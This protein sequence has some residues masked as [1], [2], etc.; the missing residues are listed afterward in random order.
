MCVQDGT[1]Y[2]RR[3]AI[4]KKLGTELNL[5]IDGLFSRFFLGDLIENEEEISNEELVVINE[6]VINEE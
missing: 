4:K 5:D 2:C 1:Y 3:S 6:E